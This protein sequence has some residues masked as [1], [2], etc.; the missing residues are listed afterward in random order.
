MAGDKLKKKK[1]SRER[2]QN[3]WLPPDEEANIN[4]YWVPTPEEIEDAKRRLRSG[5]LQ[6]DGQGR[7]RG[8]EGKLPS[9]RS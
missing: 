7:P 3:D 2:C 1:Y 5:Q 4:G 8:T 6:L 9:G